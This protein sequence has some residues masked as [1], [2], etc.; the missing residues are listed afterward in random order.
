MDCKR[1]PFFHLT[2]PGLKQKI[3]WEDVYPTQLLEGAIAGIIV[4]LALGI[5]PLLDGEPMGA[6]VLVGRRLVCGVIKD[7]VTSWLAKETAA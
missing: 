4:S 2:Y 5:T 3:S 7:L 6:V 1:L